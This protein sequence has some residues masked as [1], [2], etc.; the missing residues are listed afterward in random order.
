MARDEFVGPAL[1]EA[2]EAYLHAMTRIAAEEPWQS[3]K[4]SKLAIA[5]RVI[6]MIDEHLRIAI[7]QGVESA[8][9]ID[10]A[11]RVADIPERRRTILQSL[12]VKL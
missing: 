2:R 6:D 9:A 11:R 12:G 1:D 4:I 3:A 8:R 7:S 10:H 5:Q